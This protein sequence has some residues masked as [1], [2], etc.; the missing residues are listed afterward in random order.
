MN[1]IKIL[2]ESD[3]KKIINMNIA[4]NAVERLQF[5]QRHAKVSK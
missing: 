2:N 3:I 1:K 4:I 5:S